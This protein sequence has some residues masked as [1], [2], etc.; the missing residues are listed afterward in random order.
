MS[1]IPHKNESDGNNAICDPFG[2][3]LAA[4]IFHILPVSLRV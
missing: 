1:Y 4:A 2:V 3:T